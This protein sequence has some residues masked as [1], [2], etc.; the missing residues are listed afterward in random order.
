M[1]PTYR[2]DTCGQ[3]TKSPRRHLVVTGHRDFTEGTVSRKSAWPPVV[4]FSPAAEP[5][6]L[7]RRCDVCGKTSTPAGI[8]THQRY[9]G[10]EG[11]TA[12]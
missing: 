5:D 3:L 10:H 11:W 9:S 2:C 6:P 4:T 8:G 7:H 12:V 1:N